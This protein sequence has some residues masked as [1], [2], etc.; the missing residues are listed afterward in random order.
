MI[1]LYTPTHYQFLKSLYLGFCSSSQSPSADGQHFINSLDI[2]IQW[3]FICVTSS[4]VFCRYRY[5]CT[6]SSVSNLDL[7][8]R[9]SVLCVEWVARSL[10]APT[11]LS[12]LCCN[13]VCHL[14]IDHS[15]HDLEQSSAERSIEKGLHGK[16]LSKVHCW[17][18]NLNLSWLA[19]L[20]EE[21]LAF[22]FEALLDCSVQVD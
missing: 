13:A 16:R 14:S 6:G 5:A 12:M 17:T 8:C 20:C 18:L 9:G 15:F 7:V 10:W 1:W 11:S 3:H 2:P 22:H 19:I 4:A 21:L